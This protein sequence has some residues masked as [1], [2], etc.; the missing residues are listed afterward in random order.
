M[1]SLKLIIYFILAS[2]GFTGQSEEAQPVENLDVVSENAALVEFV[3]V[4]T[5]QDLV[6]EKYPVKR[7]FLN[8]ILGNPLLGGCGS[9]YYLEIVK[10]DLGSITA[11]NNIPFKKDDLLKHLHFNNFDIPFRA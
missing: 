1:R 3:E 8:D 4:A 6:R 10:N 2:N 11:E 9:A 7:K 5:S